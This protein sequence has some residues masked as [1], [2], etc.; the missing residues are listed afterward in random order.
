[1]NIFMVVFLFAGVAST[2]LNAV[3][4]AVQDGKNEVVLRYLEGGGDPD[5]IRVQSDI[6]RY[7]TLPR[8]LKK[9]TLLLRAIVFGREQ[10]AGALI[11]HGASLEV[12]GIGLGELLIRTGMNVEAKRVVDKACGSQRNF[13]E[14]HNYAREAIKSG[15]AEI[16]KSMLSNYRMLAD[17][18]TMSDSIAIDAVRGGNPDIVALLEKNGLLGRENMQ[19]ARSPLAFACE[20]GDVKIAEALIKAGFDVNFSGA[21]GI[22]P[23][24]QAAVVEPENPELIELLIES[25]AS[26]CVRDDRGLSALNYAMLVG[27]LE[28]KEMLRAPA[29]CEDGG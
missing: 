3:Y 8:T 11:S 1:M 17:E 6:R 29:T 21:G 12:G 9:E 4:E 22:T 28:I 10:I 23:L 5:L 27:H 13:D 15:N 25:G 14:C 2:D 24:M 20:L 16:F 26:K 18:L 19:E 7:P